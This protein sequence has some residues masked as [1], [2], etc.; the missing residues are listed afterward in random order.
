ME[1]GHDGGE[2]LKQTQT[3]S[4]LHIKETKENKSNNK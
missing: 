2:H 3:K 4:F 1:G